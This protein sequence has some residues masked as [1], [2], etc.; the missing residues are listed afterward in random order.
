[1]I[2]RFNTYKKVTENTSNPN[3]YIEKLTSTDID[4]IYDGDLYDD[5]E[6]IEATISYEIEIVYR[7]FG[8]DSLNPHHC[9]VVL[10]V[11]FNKDD[12]SI[13]KTFNFTNV[14]CDT[15]NAR[16]PFHPDSLDVNL[17]ENKIII[18]F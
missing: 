16:L 15:S 4:L 12:E 3:Q 10:Y 18:N 9:S 5:I 6:S 7:S 1:M 13:E 2:Q 17:K 11:T 14:E 8:I